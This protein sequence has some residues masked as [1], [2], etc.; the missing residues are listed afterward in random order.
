MLS[1]FIWMSRFSF[2]IRCG[3]FGL[4]FPYSANSLERKWLWPLLDQPFTLLVSSAYDLLL[5]PRHR[6]QVS[7]AVYHIA[8][9]ISH[10]CPHWDCLPSPATIGCGLP[11]VIY[12]SHVI[13]EGSKVPNSN[14]MV[15]DLVRIR[16]VRPSF[17][18]GNISFCSLRSYF[19]HS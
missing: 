4:S 15:P 16:S 6:V 1:S 2:K 8:S 3:T 9:N 17:M 10:P 11:E 5:S 13:S 7:V 18:F 14:R 19:P 12:H